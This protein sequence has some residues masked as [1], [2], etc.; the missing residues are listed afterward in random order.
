MPGGRVAGDGAPSRPE[1]RGL[2]VRVPRPA[3]T[4]S[5]SSSTTSPSS[6]A[7]SRSGPSSS[8]TSATSC[9]RR[10]RPSRS[11][12]RRSD[13]RPR[14]T[15]SPSGCATGS[16]ASRSRPG[17]SPRWSTR[18]WTS[19]GS[20]AARSSASR[21][22][23]TSPASP[24]RPPSAS[25]C[26]RSGAA[27]TLVTDAE[28]DLPTVR[29][30]EAR[31]GQVVVNLVHNAVKFSPDGGEVR[32]AVQRERRG[33]RARGHRPRH[34][35]P[36]GRPRAHLR[37]LLQGGPGPRAWRRD[38]PRPLDRPARRRGPRRPH[39]G[40]VGG[41]RGL[42][43]HDDH[44]R[45]RP[46][47][48]GRRAGPCPDGGGAR[49]P[50]AR[51]HPQHPEP[52]RPLGERLPLL[53]A[54][55]GRAGAGRHGAQRGRL[56][57]PAGPPPG[58]RRRQGR[59]EAV[60]GWAGR[61]EYGN[62]LLVRAPLAATD[63]DRLDLGAL[64]A[65]GPP[66]AAG[67]GPPRGRRHPS[68]PRPGRRGGPRR[69]GGH[70]SWPGWT[71]PGHD[72]LVVVGDFNAE[73]T[74]PARADA[75]GGLRVGLRE[76]ERR[77]S[78]RSP[79]RPGLVAPG[80]DTDGDP[81]CL[82]YVWVRG[83]ARVE[84]ARLASTAPPWATPRC[85]RRTTSAWRRTWSS[86]ECHQRRA[87]A[88]PG[89]PRRLAGRARRTRSPRCWPRPASRAATGW[90][91]TCASPGT[92]SRCC[93]TTR[94][95]P[96]SRAG[97]EA[98]GRLDA[99]QLAAHD[100][101]RLADALAALP[102][103]GWTSSSRARATATPPP[104]S[105]ARR[106]ATPPRA[107]SISSFEPPALVAMADRLPGWGRWLNAGGPRA[108]HAVARPRAR[109][110]RRLG[111]VGRDHARG[112]GPCPDAGPGGRGLDGP[113]APDVRAAGAPGRRRLL[114]GGRRPRRV[115]PGARRSG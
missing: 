39:R 94:R 87:P 36:Q 83:A 106:A 62:S 96:A 54:G 16:S 21:T 15:R 109:L 35:H 68:P 72:A 88:A 81:G 92:V 5:S 61:P 18:C 114:R 30:D 102:V 70:G 4:S 80:M 41:G 24:P 99:A 19:R 37:A 34:R 115:A 55:H 93:S 78:R 105:C 74:E 22:T 14:P 53:L 49:G 110:P 9:G 82:D 64:R 50:R 25:A 103:P 113:P 11:S 60:R 56:P 97:A 32:V 98:S 20:R 43:V 51:R 108:R 7:C 47:R 58:R 29:G 107:P 23:S 13:A 111:P 66:G 104:P 44:P 27:S 71:R 77:W 45:R 91:S 31:L 12:R 40:R 79:G 33:G 75:G 112:A 101:P 85:T 48:P 67:R 100:V 1:P 3:P 46:R 57:A 10:C 69:A 38:R 89:A 76:R 28:P 59:Y 8:T 42:H 17:T 26:S 90:S 52:R 95:S 6:G 73:P 2:L 65:P 86:G 63:A 84:A